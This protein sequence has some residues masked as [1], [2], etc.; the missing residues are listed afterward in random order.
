MMNTRRAFGIAISLDYILFS[1]TCGLQH[2][3][4]S[5]VMMLVQKNLYE[6]E[7]NVIY[8]LYFLVCF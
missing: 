5:P 2:L 3:I 7:R 1:I 4:Y 6:I 8:A